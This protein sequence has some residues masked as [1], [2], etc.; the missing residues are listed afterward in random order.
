MERKSAD[1]FRAALTILLPLQAF[2]F[3][4]VAA[5]A[6]ELPNKFKAN[7]TLEMFG[8][9]I[10]EATHTLEHTENGLS[11]TV[12]SI[13]VGLLAL[14]YEG[15]IDIRSDIVKDNGQLL[16]VNH[17]YAHSEDTEGTTVRYDISWLES[18]EQDPAASATGIY[19]GEKINI[20]SDRPIWDP[21]SIQALI[22]INADKKTASYEHGLL[23][24]DEI[25]H[26]SFENQGKE[27]I[28][29]NGTD[30]TTLK[31]VVKETKRDRV[32]YVWMLPEYHNIPIKYEHW[33]NG[34][35][36][37]TLLLQSVTFENNGEIKTLALTES[38]EDED[39]D[40]EIFE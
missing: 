33:K 14:F 21:L 2:L 15:Q 9:T 29:F 31:T 37:S 3:T 22:I 27:T 17:D 16:L 18:Q 25:K 38:P 20:D 6:I 35:K 34:K 36:K 39:K 30:F 24:K 19:K 5:L 28:R 40:D 10:A 32:I 4:P 13:P 12:S 7:Y 23:M 1:L 26:Y 11:M 8:L